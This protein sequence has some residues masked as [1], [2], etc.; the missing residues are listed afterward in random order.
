MAVQTNVRGLT[1][2]ELQGKIATILIVANN[3]GVKE[4]PLSDMRDHLEH[5]P[6]V[7]RVLASTQ[8]IEQALREMSRVG[9]I[10]FKKSVARLPLPK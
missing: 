6:R 5:D 4:I 10:V 2:Q 7:E 8:E 1:P 9:M 3:N